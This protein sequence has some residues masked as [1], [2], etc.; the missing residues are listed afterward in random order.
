MSRGPSATVQL[1][2]ALAASSLHAGAPIEAIASRETAWRSATFT[3][4]RHEVEAS[5]ASGAA[6]DRWLARIGDDELDLRG[7]LL[8]EA[9]LGSVTRA[10]GSTRF[11]LSAVTVAAA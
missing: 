9:R 6:L 1:T 4:A 2:R 7:H 10:G 8:A 11:T 3:G 5:A